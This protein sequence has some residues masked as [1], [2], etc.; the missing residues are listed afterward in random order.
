MEVGCLS[1]VG[2][3]EKGQPCVRVSRKALGSAGRSA[4]A[5][6]FEQLDWGVSTNPDHDLG[7]DL[8]LMACDAHR[9]DL[10]LLVGA[11]AKHVVLG[12]FVPGAARWGCLDD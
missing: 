5:G 4:V 11:P 2:R 10:M 6:Q 12:T 9:L 3:F 1:G 7:T 8:W